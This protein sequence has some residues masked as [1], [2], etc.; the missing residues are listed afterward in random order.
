MTQSFWFLVVKKD[1]LSEPVNICGSIYTF[2]FQ[3]VPVKIY[4]TSSFSENEEIIYNVEFTFL[5]WQI[6]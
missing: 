4:I 3:C 2:K 1:I 5:Q 6:Y